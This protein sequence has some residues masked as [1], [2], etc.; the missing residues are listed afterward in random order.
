[1]AIKRPYFVGFDGTGD[2]MVPNQLDD[3]MNARFIPNLAANQR[4]I[5][6]SDGNVYMVA[7]K[8]V[9]P[10]GSKNIIWSSEGYPS[11]GNNLT[12]STSPAAVPNANAANGVTIPAV[13]ST[14][15][16]A[17]GSS[18][19]NIGT[20]LGAT[21]PKLDFGA[22]RSLDA[23][24]T[25]STFTGGTSIAFEI[26]MQDD[27]GTPNSVAIWAP[28]ALTATQT[29][30][31]VHIGLDQP[32]FQAAAAPNVVTAHPAGFTLMADLPSGVLFYPVYAPLLPTGNFKW[33]IVG[34][35]SAIAWTAILYGRY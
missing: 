23:V 33:T 18:A 29:M 15:K 17:T 35:F 10:V 34:T 4:S 12:D 11:L 9:R 14:Q 3:P 30:M 6:G 13:T 28:A 27:A 8:S 22:F 32:F 5:L 19:T 31:I 1:M 16:K 25:L 21:A 20:L 2:I 7:D 26:D 24:I